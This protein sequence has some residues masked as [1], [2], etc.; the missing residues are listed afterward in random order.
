M[1]LNE[2]QNGFLEMSIKAIVLGIILSLILAG[3]N[4]YLGLFAALTVSATIPASVISMGVLSLLFK[5]HTIYENTQVMT[6]ASAGEALAAGVIFT[7]PA[8]V[9]MGYWEN[10]NYLWVT[11]IAAFGGVLGVLFTV[12]LRRAL[13]VEGDLKFPEGIATAEVLKSGQKGG[14]AI[15]SIAFPAIG[16]ALYKLGAAGLYLWKEAFQAAARVGGTVAYFGSNLSPALLAVG[17]IVGINIAVLIFIGGAGNWLVT[18]PLC[19]AGGI[20]LKDAAGNV[21]DP[22]GLEA[23]DYATKIWEDYTRYVGVGAMVLGGIW[24]VLKMWK[25]IVAVVKSGLDAYKMAGEARVQIPRTEKDIPIKW[26]FTLIIF[27]VVP[28]FILYQ[29]VV[30]EVSVSIPMALMMIVFGFVFSAVAGYM[31]GIVGSS[32]N[33]ISGVTVATVLLSALLLLMLM[34]SGAEHGPTAAIII[35]GVIC[36]AASIAG[37]NLQDLKSGYIVKAT[38]W[39]QEVMLIIGV[40]A[41]ALV[42]API[43][44][45]LMTA[46]G[47]EGHSSAVGDKALAAPQANLMASVAKGIFRG[48]LPWD[49]FFGGVALAACLIILDEVLRYK[50]SSFR[51]PV[52]AVAIGFYLPFKLSVPILVG[53]LLN[54]LISRYQK[55]KRMSAEQRESCNRTGLLFASG[56]ITGEAILGILLAIPIVLMEDERAIALLSEDIHEKLDLWLAVPGVVLMLFIIF[57]LYFTVRKP[58][59]N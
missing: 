2:K 58:K 15:K 10:F 22:G 23:L 49:F 55:K 28:I 45:L 34:G 44:N 40:L 6:C 1:E 21:I 3:A 47:F 53:G 46:Y 16:G 7:M 30:A 18:I 19:A 11:A 13:I 17:Y 25:S 38:P 35:G 27:S 8:L 33:P 39:K 32:N 42:M 56:L 37:D 57:W 51:T 31:A 20:E 12:P 4:A 43:L 52:L 50:G 24:A 36:C 41:A 54:L 29:V 59:E 26:V 5:R 14:A 9:I 48:G